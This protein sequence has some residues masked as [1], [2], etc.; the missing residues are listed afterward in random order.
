MIVINEKRKDSPPAVPIADELSAV[1][2]G[3]S[4]INDSTTSA[5]AFQA[6]VFPLLG[7]GIE[8]AVSIEMLCKLLGLSSPRFVRK[9]I[10]AEREHGYLILATS[11]GYFLPSEDSERGHAEMLACYR[12]LL[13]HAT[14]SF[15]FL[16]IL[17]HK[18]R[19]SP[20][21]IEIEQ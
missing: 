12:W 11:G 15:P 20:F 9:L 4:A 17:E 3:V 1:N 18:L 21:Q 7:Y 13:A 14:A 16:R 6:V 2:C 5:Q 10:K 19:V 8:N